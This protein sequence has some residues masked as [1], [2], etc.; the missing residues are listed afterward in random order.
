VNEYNRM[1]NE[2]AISAE[3]LSRSE[4][5]SAW[6]EMAKQVAHEIKNPLTP[7]KLHLQHLQ[8]SIQQ[9]SEAEMREAIQRTAKILIEQI[10]SL[11]SIATEFSNFANMPRSQN[12]VLDLKEIISSVVSLFNQTPN[13]E[14]HISNQHDENKVLADR[15]QLQRVFS[16]LIKNAIQSIP[17]DRKG[18]IQI[19]IKKENNTCIV[20]VADNGI[21]IAEDQRAK[22]F[23][24]SFTTKSTGMGLGLAIVKSTI[25]QAGG[26][27]WFESKEHE[28][29]TFF[30]ELPAV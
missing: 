15:Q 29:A 5:E 26:S 17:E 27:V 12:Q 19:D 10:D 14:I 2:L 3:K 18:R 21:G 7:M 20:S 13:I 4:R 28:G 6:R 25:E 1:I 9:S 8:R 30:V 11:S 23:S 24:P 22:I 16:N